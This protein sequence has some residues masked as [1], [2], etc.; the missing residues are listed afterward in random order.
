LEKKKIS[1]YRRELYQYAS[2]LFILWITGVGIFKVQRDQ[3][4]QELMGESLEQLQ[5]QFQAAQSPFDKLTQSF[6]NDKNTLLADMLASLPEKAKSIE[7]SGKKILDLFYPEYKSAKEFGLAD[8][9]VYNNSGRLICS[10][11]NPGK[12]LLSTGHPPPASIRKVITSNRFFKGFEN[13]RAI[14][15]LRYLYPLFHHGEFIGLYEWVWSHKAIIREMRRLDSRPYL[16]LFRKDQI[17]PENLSLY[18]PLPNCDSFGFYRIFMALNG[19]S[20]ELLLNKI[21]HNTGVCPK[22]DLNKSQVEIYHDEGHRNFLVELL[23]L[24]SLTGEKPGYGYLFSI[25]KEERI[26]AI[27]HFF[28]LELV[29]SAMAMILTFMLLY[30]SSWESTFVRTI[31]DTQRDL[32]ILTNSERLLDANKAFLDFFDVSDLKE[33]VERYGCICTRFLHQDGYLHRHPSIGESW[34]QY[35]RKH[36]KQTRVKMHDLRRNEYRVFIIALNPFNDAGLYVISFRDITEL[37]QEK[38]HFKIVSMLDHLTQIYNKRTF[39][40]YLMDRLQS[41][42]KSQHDEVAL[43]MFDIDHFKQINDRYG[44]LKGD[45]VLKKLTKLVQ[46][47]IRKE[48]FLARWGGEEFMIVMDAY[49]LEKTCHKIDEIRL[50]IEKSSLGVPEKITC[51]FG[52]TMLH[53]TD[54]FDEVVSRVDE[55]LYLAKAQGRNRVVCRQK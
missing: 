44:H 53:P 32:V 42:R 35:L 28:I 51:S 2:I 23:Q 27:N 55:L 8:F 30:H 10:F 47:H 34:L 49:D 19:G 18:Y 38:H 9:S 43:V 5:K 26:A 11:S 50:L 16:F 25:K 6:Y 17:H 22:L 45:E 24:P 21:T 33:F 20:F 14:D 46:D 40:T 15:G 54:T 52:V 37:E 39:E 13:G 31:I 1:R 3:N 4:L 48:D 41:L 36:P 29:V 7:E 12:S